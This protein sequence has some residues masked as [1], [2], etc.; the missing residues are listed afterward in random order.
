MKKLLLL[1]A[2]FPLVMGA[3]A[4][5]QSGQ[6]SFAVDFVGNSY[7][8]QGEATRSRGS[9]NA[10]GVVLNA[11]NKN[12]TS[13]Y[14]RNDSTGSVSMMLVGFAPQG[15]GEV[16]VS[17]L[18]K[19]FTVKFDKNT[20]DS[21]SFGSVK[22]KTEGYIKVDF[23]P[24]L[25]SV[26]LR[27]LRISG[28]VSEKTLSYVHD[29]STYWGNRGP[30][31][32]MSYTQPKE[33]SR[34]FYN[35]V[36]VPVGQD[37]IGSYYMA[38]GFG[39]GYFGMQ[40]NSAT[41]R[42]VLFSVWSPFVTDDPKSIPDS[43]QIV[44]LRQGKDVRIGEFG[45]EGSGGQSYLVFPWKAGNT[46]KF[47]GSVVPDGKGSTVYTAYFFAPE[48][49]AWRLIASFKRPQ[50]NT[51]YQRAHSFLENFSPTQGWIT[52]QVLFGNQWALGVDGVWRE[53]TEAQFTYD[54][55]ASAGVR[56]DYAGGELNGQFFLKNCGF[57]DQNTPYRAKFTRKATGVAPKIDFQ[58]LEKL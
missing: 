1:I 12:T 42:R 27:S 28:A 3:A 8:T 46:Y 43:M 24:L 52:R 29:F 54:A 25:G 51:D 30:S 9:R 45:N 56:K 44:K 15:T 4:Q 26:S 55:T 37:V 18:G 11:D 39:E 6:K 19:D 14:F 49:G 2:L 47:L 10:Q 7:T 16:K 48:E 17:V 20:L 13:L 57:F 5:G 31:V 33:P 40:C 22:T 41:E 32:H 36:T 23:T 34:W 35:E 21:V 50:T 38:N 53:I 58:A